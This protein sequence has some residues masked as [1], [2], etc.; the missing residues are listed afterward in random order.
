M[1]QLG[2]D[3]AEFGPR[4]G[5]VAGQY[6]HRI[7]ENVDLERHRSRRGSFMGGLGFFQ[8]SRARGEKSASVGLRGI[9]PRRP[10]RKAG[11]VV[12]RVRP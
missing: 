6:E 2:G 10:S 4:A 9:S 5:K 3:A 11:M 7:I 1:G 12:L 8:F